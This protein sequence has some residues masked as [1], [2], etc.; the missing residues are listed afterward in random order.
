MVAMC[1]MRR[2]ANTQRRDTIS[3]V[4]L[5]PASQSEQCWVLLFC[6][7]CVFF[8]LQSEDTKT[9]KCFSLLSILVGVFY[10]SWCRTWPDSIWQD[11]F[12]QFIESIQLIQFWVTALRWNKC[13]IIRSYHRLSSRGNSRTYLLRSIRL[14]ANYVDFWALLTISVACVLRHTPNWLHQW[15]Y[16]TRNVVKLFTWNFH[17][18]RNLYM[19]HISMPHA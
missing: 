18:V 19:L 3:F 1:C 13:S 4:Q 15:G 11:C 5:C 8:F 9:K 16:L 6:F 10:D 12:T 17:S 7:S 14:Q 2:L